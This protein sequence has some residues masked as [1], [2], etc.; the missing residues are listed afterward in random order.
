MSKLT[1]R[2]RAEAE[3]SPLPGAYSGTA[4]A[5]AY[6]AGAQQPLHLHLIEIAAGETLQIHSGAVDQ[7]AY[8][9]RG[10]VAAGGRSLAA[11]SSL[12]IEHGA[13]VELGGVAQISA[14]LAF[15]AARPPAR[16]RAGGHVHLLPAES[17]PR[18]AALGGVAGLGGA[19]HADADCPTCE[20]WLHE[21]QFAGRDAPPQGE[22]AGVHCHSEDEIIFVVDGELRLGER[23]YG[24][25]TA[26]AIAADAFYSFSPGPEGLRFVNFRAGRP[27]DIRFKK[28]PAI[29][30]TAYW[31]E[32]L[33][34]PEYLAPL[35]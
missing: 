5:A 24:P 2:T 6:Y 30:E 13:S 31:R 16:P 4:A 25:G 15:A 20:L 14:V 22:E 27:S 17:A 34:R 32:R 11:G 18:S 29:S 7:L 1:V 26:L 28:G 19:M 21:N 35:E 3:R 9:W 33:P 12:I 8:I 10:A 23:L